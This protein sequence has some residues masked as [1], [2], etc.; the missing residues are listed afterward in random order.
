MIHK[1]YISW[2]RTSLNI[3]VLLIYKKYKPEKLFKKNRK[4]KDLVSENILMG[5]F[6]QPRKSQRKRQ[7]LSSL[8]MNSSSLMIECKS[9]LRRDIS[10]IMASSS[11]SLDLMMSPSPSRAS[12]MAST[13]T[14]M[15]LSR[16]VI[17][18]SSLSTFFFI[19]FTWALT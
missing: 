10:V 8:S 6:I 18:L 3:F 15:T 9:N 19:A 14:S 5:I 11:S 7:W 4:K 1:K 16:V 17:L 12:I 2:N 13:R